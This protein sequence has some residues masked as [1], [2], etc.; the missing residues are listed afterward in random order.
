MGEME[1][2]KI[3]VAKDEE[4]EKKEDDQA[5][6]QEGEDVAELTDAVATATIDPKEEEAPKDEPKEDDHEPKTDEIKKKEPKDEWV[7]I[8]DHDQVRNE[9]MDKDK[10]NKEPQEAVKPIQATPN[11]ELESPETQKVSTTKEEHH[12]DDD[13]QEEEAAAVHESLQA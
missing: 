6:V 12:Q 10:E 3:E 8:L 11:A 7:E 5:P 1:E 13:N 9:W 4:E 2:N